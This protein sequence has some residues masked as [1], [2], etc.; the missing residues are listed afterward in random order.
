MSSPTIQVAANMAGWGH[1]TRILALAL[2]QPQVQFEIYNAVIPNLPLPKWIPNIKRVYSLQK[3]IPLVCE[4][5][6]ESLNPYQASDFPKILCVRKTSRESPDPNVYTQVM[7]VSDL[8]KPGDFSPVVLE[9]PL[10]NKPFP[11]HVLV[12]NEASNLEYLRRLHP[13][14]THK[15]VHPITSMRQQIEH[16]VGIGSYNLFWE[17]AYYGIPCRLYPSVWPNDSLWRMGQ[18]GERPMPGHFENGAPALS[19]AIWSWWR[20][21]F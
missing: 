1:W 7:T 20:E 21:I 17:C 14:Y 8:D 3:G 10:V 12:C 16:L 9:T 11:N 15:L 2:H 18:L 13:D 19:Q 4:H 5:G 6:F